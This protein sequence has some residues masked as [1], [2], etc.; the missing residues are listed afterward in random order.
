MQ[1][2]RPLIVWDLVLSI[3]LVLALLGATV[4]AAMIALFIPMVSDGCGEG[5][6][7]TQIEVGTVLALALPLIA[8]IAAIVVTI[9]FLVKR[10]LAFWVP[11]AGIGLVGISVV[12]GALIAMTAVPGFFG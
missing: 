9:V 7:I 2:T 12:A 10:R 3:V 4:V 11:L 8:S 1:N 6:S 5:C